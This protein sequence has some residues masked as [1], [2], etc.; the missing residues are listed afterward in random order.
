MSGW[1][2]QVVNSTVEAESPERFYYWAALSSLS[3]VARKSVYLDRYYYKLYPNIY[4]FLIARSGL[5]KSNPVTLAKKVVILAGNTKV[6]SG[7]NS[8]QSVLKDIGKAFST[9]SG[10]VVKDAHAFMVSGELASFLVKDPDGLTILTDLHDT[11]AN[12]PEWKNSLKTQGTDT[13]RNPCITLLG[14]S[15]QEHFRDAVPPNAIGGGFIA[16]TFIV[17][18]NHRRTIN[19]LMDKPQIV[20]DMEELS[21][22]LKEV[23]KVKGEFQIQKEARAFYRNWY[24]EL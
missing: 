8:I 22:Y 19:D 18:E 7:R 16:R 24:H 4:V 10:E 23:A 2:D 6:I 1:I 21:C 20:P 9:E 17:M 3:A 11:H 13:L 15:N 12:E 14:A 5:R